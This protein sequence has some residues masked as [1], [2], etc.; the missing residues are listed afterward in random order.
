[1][2][3]PVVKEISFK[4]IFLLSALVGILFSRAERSEHFL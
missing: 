2:F 3:G 4:K 1:M